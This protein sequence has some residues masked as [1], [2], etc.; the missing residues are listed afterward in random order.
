M[1]TVLWANQLI[2]GQVTSDESDK[3]ALYRHLD[4]LDSICK[5][6]GIPPISSFCDSTDLRFNM[7]ENLELPPGMNSTNELMAQEG[8]WI[9]AAVAEQHL[10]RLLKVIREKKTRFGLIRNDHDLVIAEL[11][12][13]IAWTKDAAACKAQ[14]NFCIVM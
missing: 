1:S 14:F 2:D 10:S 4:K 12:E 11:E 13:S 5:S 6:A 3:Y 9:D 7:D 8:I